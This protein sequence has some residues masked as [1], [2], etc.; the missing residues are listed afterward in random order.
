MYLRCTRIEYVLV[1]SLKRW[2]LMRPQPP[3]PRTG[4]LL[5]LLVLHYAHE[6]QH[7]GRSSA[8]VA[9]RSIT[10]VGCQLGPDGSTPRQAREP[11]AGRLGTWDRRAGEGSAAG[12]ELGRTRHAGWP[13]AATLGRLPLRLVTQA[14]AAPGPRAPDGC[15]C[16]D[17]K[18]RERGGGGARRGREERGVSSLH[19]TMMTEAALGNRPPRSRQASAS[20]LYVAGRACAG[21]VQ[22]ARQAARVLGEGAPSPGGLGGPRAAS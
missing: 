22:T 1:H 15:H 19:R 11:G 14:A 8:R 13:R 3:H 18:P 4:R 9:F 20:A 6:N 5:L 2:D 16:T 21:G 17:S 12:W 7:D 10:T